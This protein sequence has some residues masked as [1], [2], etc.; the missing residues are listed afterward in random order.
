MRACLAV[1]VAVAGAACLS[2]CAPRSSLL[3]DYSELLAAGVEPTEEADAV[4]AALSRAGYALD[5]RADGEGFVALGF[6]RADEGHRA[7]RVVTRRGV[8][9]ALDSGTLDPGG[10]PG[11]VHVEALPIGTDVDGDGRADVVVSRR[12]ARRSCLLVLALTE[13]GGLDALRVDAAG[14]EPDACLEAFEDVDGRAGA[15]AIVRVRAPGLRRA[16]T[17]TA[18]VPL[19]RDEAGVYG[20]RPPP[21]AYL[22][23]VRQRLSA[24]LD[25]ARARLDEEE[26]YTLAV[27]AALVSRAAGEAPAL[28]LA[29]F[30]AAVSTIV[31]S[32]AM[33]EAVRAARAYVVRG[34]R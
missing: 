23:R 21:V 27:E 7:V 4:I 6:A 10:P 26:A 25:A 14:L 20:L 5:E 11:D 19:E 33:A 31:W 29:A 8:A 13:D 3:P 9:F 16:R 28:Q 34:W 12:E 30:D 2:A 24:A 32:E 18:D 15:E 22:A 17:P 1:V